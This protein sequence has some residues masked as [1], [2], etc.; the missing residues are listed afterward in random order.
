MKRFLID[1][2]TA[3]DDAL[4]LLM[5]LKSKEVKVEAVTIVAGNVKFEQEVENAL[6]TIELANADYYVPVYEGCKKPI[7]RDLVTAEEVHGK[8]GMGESYLPKAKQRPE[9]M[10]AVNAIIRYAREF[11]RE[12]TIVALGPLTN[13]ALAITIERELPKLV[14]ELYVM[15]GSVGKGNITP[16][17]EYNFYVDPE[18]AKIVLGSKFNLTLID[19]ELCINYGVIKDKEYEEIKSLKTKG[20]EFYCKITRVLREHDR[21]KGL[22][23]MVHA[24]ALA[25][26]IAINPGIA[27]RKELRYVDIETQGEL[28]RGMSVVAHISNREANALICYEANHD[29]FKDILIDALRKTI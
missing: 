25:M 14:K 3:T 28:T 24:D 15:G 2:D 16:V 13:L 18:A 27:E 4:A 8:D 21:K 22:E 11:Q 20:S 23:G 6:Y 29:K 5:A 12:L 10:H 26:S 7:L 17:A 19:W 1:T 9:K